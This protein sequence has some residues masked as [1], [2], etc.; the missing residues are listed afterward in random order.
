MRS[1][2]Q[3]TV[4]S[5]LRLVRSGW[6]PTLAICTATLLF[7][8]A[9]APAQ[10]ADCPN[11]KFTLW[12]T[13]SLRGANIFQGRNPGGAT[14]GIGDGD[15][16]QADYDELAQAGANYVHLSH[17]GIFAEA[18]PYRLDTAAFA[19][20][21]A[22]VAKAS[23]AGM[24]VGIAFRSGPGRNENAI[25]NRDGPL[26]DA[27]W[28]NQAAQDAWRAMLA[29]TAEHFR[30]NPRVVGLSVMVE[31]NAY[32]RHGYPD[33]TE[34]YA[35]RAGSLEDVNQLYSAATAAIRAVDSDIP[36]L[37]EPEGY[38]NVSW[39]P[40]L[41]ATGDRRTVYTPHDYT[42]YEFSHETDR[43]AV[44]PGRYELGA[45]QPVLVDATFLRGY[46]DTMRSYSFLHGVPVALTEFGV[47]RTA[48]RADVYLADRIA[49]QNSIGSWAV[50]VWQPAGFIDPFSVHQPSAVLSTLRNAW[51]SNCRAVDTTPGGGGQ[52][53]EVGSI[54]GRAY[55]VSRRGRIGRP[56]SGVAVTAD[57]I[58]TST[59]GNR[60]H[61]L[62]ALELP[63]GSHQLA[64]S[65]RKRSC[66]INGVSGPAVATVELNASE[67]V[68][69]DIYCRRS[70][71]PARRNLG[72]PLPGKAPS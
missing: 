29:A 53:G 5:Q 7:H 8:C 2:L 37:L 38:G 70:P 66:F 63:A 17:A 18:P 21:D 34:F 11:D 32:A 54:T 69:V 55:A 67:V 71:K 14:N 62:Y 24:Y 65:A 57:G 3:R 68:S 51:A 41:R 61:R 9:I 23:R 31:P 36:I 25:S 26:N 46:L 20:L 44:Y 4:A 22:A 33:P 72:I 6:C 35:A 49:V 12:T 52:P 16:S 43:R 19:N 42:P 28:T 45:G 50:W 59:T 58:Q 39:L 56:M 60:K 15:F 13:G 1:G 48:P 64:A 27:I 40:Y 30:S 10:A 47:H